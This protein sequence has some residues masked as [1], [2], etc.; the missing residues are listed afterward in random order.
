MDTHIPQRTLMSTFDAHSHL[1]C[2][3]SFL[4]G[5][6][7]RETTNQNTTRRATHLMIWGALKNQNQKKRSFSG[8]PLKKPSPLTP[9][10]AEAQTCANC[11]SPPGARLRCPRGAGDFQAQQ[12]HDQGNSSTLCLGWR[13]LDVR[14][15]LLECCFCSFV[16]PFVA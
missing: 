15:W 14:V 10:P 2:G 4:F 16:F 12:H 13:F 11:A 5:G 6:I 8:D 3:G 1:V 9:L 7:K